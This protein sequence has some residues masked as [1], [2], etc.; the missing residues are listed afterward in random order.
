SGPYEP[1]PRLYHIGDVAALTGLTEHAL[2]AWE[3]VEL[4]APRRS[5]TG[6]RLYTEDD[7]ARIRLISRTLDT[8]RLSRR[9]VAEL[10]RVG[11][12]RPDAADYA[13]GGV[14]TR[15]RRG[16]VTSEG[17]RQPGDDASRT[18]R[19]LAAVTRVGGAVASGRPLAE[20]LA[21]ICRQTCVA[22]GVS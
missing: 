10:L 4:L 18:Q 21:V 8:R 20:V 9:A 1:D 15:R 2:R 5:P 14:T 7:L 13:H 19:L 6:V 11:E 16:Q 17:V 3:R 22:F 12:L